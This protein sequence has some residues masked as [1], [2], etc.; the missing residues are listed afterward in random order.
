M[1]HLNYDEENFY[2]YNFHVQLWGIFLKSSFN[3]MALSW[4]WNNNIIILKHK[5]KN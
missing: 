4:H 3:N 5:I 1:P 2:I